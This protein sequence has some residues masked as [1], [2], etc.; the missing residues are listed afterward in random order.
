M[1]GEDIRRPLGITY[2][3]PLDVLTR[4]A[5]Y[6]AGSDQVVLARGRVRELRLQAIDGPFT[7]GSGPLVSGRTLA[8]VMAMTGRG[9]F[10][11]E[12]IGDGVAIL[13][14]RC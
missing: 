2:D 4:V 11:D 8:L 7:T 6:Y 5:R 9:T 12:L 14:A 10:C 13:R 3:H 1:H